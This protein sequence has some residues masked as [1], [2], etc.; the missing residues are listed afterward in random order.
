[1]FM[2]Y[3]EDLRARDEMGM[4]SY[5]YHEYA[6]ARRGEKSYGV[7]SGRKYKRMSMMAGK[8]GKKILA[9]LLYEGH[10]VCYFS[11]PLLT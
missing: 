2:V 11:A 9:P 1:M 7:I 3:S 4:D 10:V 5:M 8:C 6:R